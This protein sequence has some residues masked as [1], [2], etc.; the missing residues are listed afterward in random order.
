MKATFY[1]QVIDGKLVAPVEAAIK[2][3]VSRFNCPVKIEVS[4]VKRIRSLS[5]NS[6]YWAVVVTM[7]HEYLVNL[8]NDVNL[9][10]THLY[11]K[12]H[13]GNLS[14]II[15]DKEGNAREVPES[16]AGLNTLEFENY[17]ESIRAWAASQGL[18]IPLPNEII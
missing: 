12:Y 18:I 15:L 10:E 5:Q 11:L 8:G 16:T 17:M 7:V 2:Q 4:E 1:S 13:V 3:F 9:E 14:K 6:Y